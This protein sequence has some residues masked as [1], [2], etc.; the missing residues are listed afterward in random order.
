METKAGDP[1]AFAHFNLS[2][3][4]SPAFV[5]DEAAIRR[6]L[7]I[8]ADVKT[9]A[10]IKILCAMKAF[11][12]WSLAPVVGEYLDGVCSSGLWESR[13]AREKYSGEIGRASCRERV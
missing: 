6:N 4:D 5:V 9:R 8:L 2:R 12:M 10:G 11:S 7:A 13:L 3:V 1:G